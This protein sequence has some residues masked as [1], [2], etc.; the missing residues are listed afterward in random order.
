MDAMEDAVDAEIETV[1]NEVA[2][3]GEVVTDTGTLDTVEE[4]EIETVDTMEADVVDV[5]TSKCKGSFVR[6]FT[7]L[8]ETMVI[9]GATCL[10]GRIKVPCL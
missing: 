5:D 8:L 1:D 10:C 7:L 9:A 4:V 3:D 6:R 2:V